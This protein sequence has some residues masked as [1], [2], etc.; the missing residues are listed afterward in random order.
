VEVNANGAVI[1]TD[2]STGLV[3]ENINFFED[4]GDVGDEYNYSYPEKDGWFTSDKFVPRVTVAETGPVRASLR[5]EHRLVAPKEATQDTKS[6]STEMAELL[7]ETTL[8]MSSSS[9]RVD[10]KTTVHNVCKDHRFRVLFSTG[11]DTTESYADTPFAVVHRTHQAYDTRQFPFEHPA[12]V[13]P[14]Q[15]FV[16]IADAS[17]GCTLIVKGLPEYELKLDKRGKLA[18]TLLRCVGKL[19]GRDLITR[20]GGAAGWW[21]E[22]P[23]AQCLGTHTFEYSVVPHKALDEHVWGSILEQV[24]DFTVPMISVK[25]KNEQLTFEREFLAVE[26]KSLLLT[27]LKR[28]DDNSGIIVRLNNPV[29]HEVRGVL[30]FTPKVNK[31]HRAMMNEEILGPAEIHNEHEIP[32]TVKAFEVMTLLVQL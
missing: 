6:R 2:K 10:I 4:S 21:N 3:Y 30:T 5:I 9:R 8:S 24:E 14:M 22:T 15:R 19:S 23:D 16:T 32:V 12:M 27:G 28:S 18:L 20:P 11:I 13:A 29:N 17:K 31:A 25:R 1:M 7:V 26:P